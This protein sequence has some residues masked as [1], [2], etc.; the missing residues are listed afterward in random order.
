[1]S[2]LSQRRSG[3]DMPRANT[4]SPPNLPLRPPERPRL[5]IR[6]PRGRSP[7]S[8]T[9]RVLH[10]PH[11]LPASLFP[12]QKATP[13]L[14]P[15]GRTDA[16]PLHVF[17]PHLL[18]RPITFPPPTIRAV[19]LKAA[20]PGTPHLHSTTAN[21]PPPGVEHIPTLHHPNTSPPPHHTPHHPPPTP[22]PKGGFETT[23]H[24]TLFQHASAPTPQN[25][26]PTQAP[27]TLRKKHRGTQTPEKGK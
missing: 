19:R 23:P 6:A 16:G 7:S 2:T 3:P 1:M 17:H 15:S 13:H 24:R 25:T 9:L 26:P 20:A 27:T 14:L 10:T 21:H 5:P 22:T 11:S 8:G 4:P 18:P 12:P